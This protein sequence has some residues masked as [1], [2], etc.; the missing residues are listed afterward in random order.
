MTSFLVPRQMKLS[1]NKWNFLSVR[2]IV[3]AS[4]IWLELETTV[5]YIVGHTHT[6]TTGTGS[7]GEL[8]RPPDI[9]VPWP[10]PVSCPGAGRGDRSAL[11]HT[12]ARASVWTRPGAGY[13]VISTPGISTNIY[14]REYL[15]IMSYGP[16]PGETWCRVSLLTTV[17]RG[18]RGARRATG[19][20][21]VVKTGQMERGS[22]DQWRT[23]AVAAGML[24][25]SEGEGEEAAT[26]LS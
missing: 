5:R 6:R 21:R 14:T 7:T 8:R 23:A 22:G 10:D 1:R 20:A 12:A 3:Q 24:W 17:S 15:L 11:A 18:V 25:R 2:G 13:L 4:S 9:A 16:R 26:W 19:G